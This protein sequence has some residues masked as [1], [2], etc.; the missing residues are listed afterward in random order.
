MKKNRKAENCKRSQFSLSSDKK[1]VQFK[2]SDVFVI[3][4]SPNQYVSISLRDLLFSHDR[5]LLI[6]SV[7][8]STVFGQ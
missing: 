2:Y 7:E 8:A 5:S 3:F 6:A 1:L 4:G